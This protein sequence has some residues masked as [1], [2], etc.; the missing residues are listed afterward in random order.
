MLKET[1][2]LSKEKYNLLK[3][4]NLQLNDDLYWESNHKKYPK[5]KYFSN[6]FAKNHSTL[7][8]LFYIHKLCYAKIKYFE[9]N[10]NKYIPYKYDYKKGFIECELFDMEFILHIPSNVIIDIRNLQEIKNIDEFHDFCR[11][12]ESYEL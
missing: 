1:E 12:L 5:V 3:K 7:A 11:Y 6:K 9:K 2:Y 8:L 4:Y 10:F